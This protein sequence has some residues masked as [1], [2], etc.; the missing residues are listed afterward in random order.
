MDLKELASKAIKG[1]LD[2]TFEHHPVHSFV[3]GS[4]EIQDNLLAF[5]GIAG[6][7]VLDTGSGL[8]MLDAGHIIDIERFRPDLPVTLPS[9]GSFWC[10]IGAR[11]IN[12][13][14]YSSMLVDFFHIFPYIVS[15]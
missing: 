12:V 3:D 10:A 6:F 8:V 1:E 9:D 5:K 11:R 2:L 15:G 13:A 14:K 7:F 4:T